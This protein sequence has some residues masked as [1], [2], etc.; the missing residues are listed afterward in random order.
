MAYE[1][2]AAEAGCEVLYF[3]PRRG[4][5]LDGVEDG[6]EVVPGVRL[7]RLMI[8]EE[9]HDPA[10]HLAGRHP[11]TLREDQTWARDTLAGIMSRFLHPSATAVRFDFGDASGAEFQ[12]LASCLRHGHCARHRVKQIHAAFRIDEPLD[13]RR[14]D[15]P[16]ETARLVEWVEALESL[17]REGF[18]SV[19][20]SPLPGGGATS[21]L[22]VPTDFSSRRPDI[23]AVLRAAQ[24]A[25]GAGFVPTAGA[26][27]VKVPAMYRQSLVA[28]GLDEAVEVYTGG[29]FRSAAELTA[30][31]KARFCAEADELAKARHGPGAK[32]NSAACPGGFA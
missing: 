17:G 28:R 27:I 15:G 14:A 25:G 20:A 9:A 30:S 6:G 1:T 10:V 26:S 23:M 18:M 32:V 3:N 7:H 24:G 4:G 31:K 16:P 21:L 29:A 5:P 19:S 11:G 8:G 2:A 12:A 13:P 22:M